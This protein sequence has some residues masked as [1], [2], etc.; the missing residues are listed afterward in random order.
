MFKT[1]TC[2]VHTTRATS[3]F[4]TAAKERSPALAPGHLIQTGTAGGRR[5]TSRRGA[6]ESAGANQRHTQAD[7]EAQAQRA[8]RKGDK[9]TQSQEPDK[10]HGSSSVTSVTRE[11]GAHRAPSGGAR[12]PPTAGISRR[13]RGDVAGVER[14]GLSSIIG[15]GLGELGRVSLPEVGLA[16]SAKGEE[17]RPVHP[18]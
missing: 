16:R 17:A 13:S 3:L 11:G 7:N 5:H 12:G 14:G 18:P 8:V 15:I 9:H 2:H 4:F 6:G 1:Q 10:S